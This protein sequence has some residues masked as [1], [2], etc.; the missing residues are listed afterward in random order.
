MGIKENGGF[1][2]RFLKEQGVSIFGF[3]D[4]SVVKEAA[5]RGMN[6]GISFA[7]ALEVFPQITEHAKIEYYSEYERV[8]NKLREISFLLEKKIREKGFNA[9]SLAHDRQNEQY[10]T[11]I[12]FKTLATRA[13]L[14]WIGR[15]ATLITKEYGNA[16]RLNGVITDMPL[17]TAE[18]DYTVRCGD[19]RR[20]VEACPANAISGRSWSLDTDRDELVDPFAC[21]AKV[22][23]RGKELGLTMCTCGFCIAACPYTQRYITSISENPDATE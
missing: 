23:E 3:A 15:S 4:M 2:C 22:I 17:E 16:I 1:V 6:Y 7:I 10:R 8:N 12:P 14:G 11:V 19:C 9:Y 21:K 18:P 20:C 5:E 13:G